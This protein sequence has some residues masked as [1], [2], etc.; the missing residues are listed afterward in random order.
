M[1]TTALATG[2]IVPVYIFPDQAPSCS[3][4]E[5]LIS[6]IAANPTIPFFLIINPDSGPGGGAGSQPD[7]TSYQ[8]CIPELKSHPNVK[9][10]GYVLTGFGSRSQSD[11]N[12]DV[13]TYAGW[14]SAYRLDG[15]FFDEVDPTSDL[16]SLYT[17]YAQDARQ[18]FGDG[19]GLVILNPGSNV[20][21]IGYFPIADQIVTAE[22]FFDDF[23]YFSHIANIYSLTLS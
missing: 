19:D 11:V 15:V 4:W 8:G 22:N 7:P 18:S 3:A 21:D 5:P 14:A 20:Q 10:V 12:S 13:A 23:R 17:T 2:I 9:T 1:A 16:L 6:A